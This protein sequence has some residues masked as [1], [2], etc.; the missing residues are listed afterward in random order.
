[1]YDYGKE[2][3]EFCYGDGDAGMWLVFNRNVFLCVMREL[4]NLVIYL[5]EAI[6][7]IW[8]LVVLFIG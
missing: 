3:Y 8:F 6:F 1:M 7:A 4:I 2:C 5:L